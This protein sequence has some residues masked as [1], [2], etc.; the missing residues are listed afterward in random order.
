MPKYRNNLPQST[1][2]MFLTD[3]G[4]E[5]VLIF[6]YGINLP[7]FA[8][9]DLL[10]NEEETTVLKNYFRDYIQLAIINNMG[11]VLESPTWRASNAWAEDT[12]YSLQELDDINR[13]AIQLMVDLR[14]E[15]ETAMS[16]I[17]ISGCIGPYS[18]GYNPATYLTVEQ[19]QKYHQQQINVLSGTQVD[20]ISGITIAYVEEAIGI[21]LAT[22][23]AD[24][25]VVISFTVETDGNLP[26]GQSLADAIQQV[27][28]QTNYAP[29]YYM[30]NCAHPT[31]FE[32]ILEGDEGWITRIQGL[33]ANASTLSHTEL[34]EAKQLDD[35]NPS[36][37]GMQYAKLQKKLHKLNI[38]GGCCGT[39]FRHIE[40]ITRFISR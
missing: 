16:P 12:G 25:P 35:G 23:E 18:D 36:E 8:A 33:R 37:L 4:L 30:I 19:A 10:K 15:Y 34:D 1:D 38:F 27:D 40:A 11:F 6:H 28:T 7:A 29:I 39:D 22:K 14:I 26:T 3:G 2:K 24:I 32:H 31:H 17:V 13:K 20:F 21:V 9:F 5:T